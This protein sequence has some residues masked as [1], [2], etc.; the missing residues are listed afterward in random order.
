[1]SPLTVTLF[2]VPELAL[3]T[4]VWALSDVIVPPLTVPPG[5][6]H[7]PVA[8]FSAS[9]EPA[10]L[11]VP[12]RSTAPV[13]VRE[14]PAKLNADVVNVPPSVSGE[15]VRLSVPGLLQ[16]LLNFTVAPSAVIVPPAALVQF[17]G[18]MFSVPPVSWIAPLLV[19]L[20][21]AT[22]SVRPA[23]SERIRPLLTSVIE[24]PYQRL[25]PMFA[26]P[27]KP[28]AVLIAPVAPIV[29]VPA[30]LLSTKRDCV[31]APSN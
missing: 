4:S 18:E 8:L 7:G 16:A 24:P 6:F 12:V 21:P 27:A 17:V 31:P 22:V 3:G 23:T 25:P 10:L 13:P 20:T 1:M 11:S 26:V 19:K 30:V 5:R 9:V 14:K 29:N 15:F 2:S 28:A